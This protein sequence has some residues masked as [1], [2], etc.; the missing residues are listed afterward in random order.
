VEAEM[1]DND[2]YIRYFNALL[3]EKTASNIQTRPSHLVYIVMKLVEAEF[4]ELRDERDREAEKKRRLMYIL[5]QCYEHVELIRI[6]AREDPDID[7]AMYYRECFYYDKV[8]L[9]Y[10]AEMGLV[11]QG[12]VEIIMRHFADQYKKEHEEGSPW[13]DESFERE[14]A[15]GLTTLREMRE[16][17]QKYEERAATYE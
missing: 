8:L 15:W 4:S 7:W 2:Y 1:A 13:H 11:N 10:C 9:T 5:E 16:K 3:K 17:Q 12:T 14:M 6:L